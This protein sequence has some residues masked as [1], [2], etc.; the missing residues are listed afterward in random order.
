MRLSKMGT[1]VLITI[2]LW[3]KDTWDHV[4]LSHEDAAIITD[5]DTQ[6]FSRFLIGDSVS[7]GRE[8]IRMQ[9]YHSIEYQ[10]QIE[11]II[12]IISA[13]DYTLQTASKNTNT[14]FLSC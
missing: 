2:R 1:G 9:W 4:S 11:Y 6:I 14:W 10:C 5:V 12:K 3:T 8:P 13:K 7:T